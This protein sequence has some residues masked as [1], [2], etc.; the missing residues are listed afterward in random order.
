MPLIAVSL[1]YYVRVLEPLYL[2]SPMRGPGA[3][4]A[5]PVAVR[6]ALVGLVIGT[7]VSGVFP[8][9]WAA[10]GTHASALLK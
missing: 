4:A 3:L 8:Q 9:S 10:L 5:E 1:F 2:R 6:A 7:I